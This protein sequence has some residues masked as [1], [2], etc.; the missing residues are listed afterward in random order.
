MRIYH[1]T[2]IEFIEQIAEKGILPRSDSGNKGNWEDLPS[3]E[4]VV[5]LSCIYAPFYAHQANFKYG[6]L[7]EIE[8]PKSEYQNLLPDE[9]FLEQALTPTNSD[10]D[11][12]Q[13]TKYFRENLQKYQHYWKKSLL[14]LGNCAYQ[15]CIPIEFIS[16]ITCWESMEIGI[17]AGQY[18]GILDISI[19]ESKKNFQRFE[20]LTQIFA[21]REVNYSHLAQLIIDHEY[22]ISRDKNE[23]EQSLVADFQKIQI[24]FERS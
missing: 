12:K 11:L 20:L 4:N 24:C 15:G 2:S 22:Y 3:E 13:W 16:R 17:I 8:I 23:L 19:E 18:N 21:K 7:I 14:K 6:A 1:G 9:D 5:Y 10:L